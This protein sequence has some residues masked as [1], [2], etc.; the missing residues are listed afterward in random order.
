[1]KNMA[2]SISLSLVFLAYA[3]A[4]DAPIA[5]D[6]DG[7][8]DSSTCA[9]AGLSCASASCCSGLSCSSQSTTCMPRSDGGTGPSD[10]AI[11]PGDGGG[12]ADG[13]NVCDPQISALA[14]MLVLS[15]TSKCAVVVR[16]DYTTRVPL[17]YHVFCPGTGGGSS[18]EA[19]AR[20]LAQSDTGFG[21]SGAM[22][23]EA[24]PPDDYV[25][26]QSPG[27]FGGVAAVSGAHGNDRVRRRHRLGGAGRHH[28]PLLLEGPGEAGSGCPAPSTPALSGRGWDLRD[29][30]AL[31]SPEV[32]AALRV[33][34]QTAVPAAIW[35]KGW[36]R[37]TIVLLYP[38]SVG[39]FNPATA[40]WIVVINADWNLT[41]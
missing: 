21:S 15:E 26:Y 11:G 29:G 5:A 3:C 34:S 17:G 1:M 30:T 32:D 36:P 7:G 19:S 4:S 24:M 31:S 2:C 27:D 13:G 38:R 6:Q 18:D 39:G 16:L 8:P 37:D 23:N 20:A 14:S 40:E 35:R 33:V 10:G 25:F 9:S 28:L 41:T 22:L 12:L